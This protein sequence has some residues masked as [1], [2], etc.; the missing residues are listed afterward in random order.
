MIYFLDRSACASAFLRP[1][2]VIRIRSAHRL[3][4]V[5]SCVRRQ[6]EMTVSD[7]VRP[8]ELRALAMRSFLD[9]DRGLYDLC[10]I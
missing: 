3:E 7:Y 2:D 10:M 1:L 5:N 4:L 8:H 6:K 9:I